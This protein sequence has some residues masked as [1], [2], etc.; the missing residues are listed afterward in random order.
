MADGKS[1]RK[2]IRYG[3]DNPQPLSQLRTEL[4]WEGKYGQ[5]GHQREVDIAGCSMPFQKIETID[6]LRAR[7]HPEAQ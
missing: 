5:Q 1:N 6:E 7:Q 2:K 4:V 3:P